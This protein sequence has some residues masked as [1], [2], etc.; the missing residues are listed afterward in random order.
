[1][2]TILRNFRK[3]KTI[4]LSISPNSTKNYLDVEDA[5]RISFKI[6]KLGK[7]RIYNVAANS[8]IKVGDILRILRIFKK[9]KIEISKNHKTTHESKINTN[10]IKKELNFSEKESFNKSFFNLIKNHY[11]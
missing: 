11:K 3:N 6:A 8:S 10:R 4:K 5:L 9:V 1:M 2:P 7:N